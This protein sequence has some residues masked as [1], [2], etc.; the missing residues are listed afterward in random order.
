[1]IDHINIVVADLE[2]AARFYETIFGFKRGFSARLEGDWIAN[3]TGLQGA[4]AQCLFLESPEG[5]APNGGGARIELIRYDAPLE[6]FSPF[7]P[8]P[9]PTPNEPGL[10]HIAFQVE[11]I[12]AT[13]KQVRALGIAPFSEPVEVPFRVADLGT[14]RLAYFHDFDGTIV[15]IASYEK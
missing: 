13:L 3:V 4:R 15:E 9:N 2:R 14:K 10:R 8:T 6:E 11:D 7:D 1:M 12:D 5:S